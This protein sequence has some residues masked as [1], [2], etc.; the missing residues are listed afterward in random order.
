[1]ALLPALLAACGGGGGD[2]GGAPAAPAPVEAAAP[3]PTKERAAS[4]I[5]KTGCSVTLEGDSIQ[6]GAYGMNQR[7][8]EPPAA[9][10]K[11][12]R[13][14][15]TVIDNSAGGSTA[16]QRAPAFVKMPVETRFVVLEHGLNDGLFGKDLA[17]ALRSMVAHVKAE[18]ATP[19]V[20]GLARQP[21]PAK[22]RDASDAIARQIA[23]E[24][25]ALFAD[26]GAVP[27][28]A[29]EMADVLHPGPAYSLRLAERLVAVLDAAAPECIP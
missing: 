22:R 26:W 12:M 18:G 7:L 13:P 21:L 10:L 25:G 1:M 8:A 29:N 28:E 20:T 11:R 24:T 19:I 9:V 14:A 27:Y 5:A 2:G 16:S 6:Y 15:Y 3:E 4:P 23:L 17:P